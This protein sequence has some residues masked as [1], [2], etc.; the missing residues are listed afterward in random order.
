MRLPARHCVRP[1]TLLALAM[2]VLASCQTVYYATMEKLGYPKRAL[3]VSRVQQARD[4]QQAAK[5]QF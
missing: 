3:L 2:L 1:S 5:E 4:S